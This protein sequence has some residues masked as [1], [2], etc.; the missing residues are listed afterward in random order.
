MRRD[1]REGRGRGEQE[2][3]RRGE[4]E[5]KWVRETNETTGNVKWR[6]RA[7]QEPTKTKR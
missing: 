4:R 6:R 1:E 3:R 5:R 7:G 2:R